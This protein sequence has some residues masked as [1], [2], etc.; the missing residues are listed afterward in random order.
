MLS[1][2]CILP[3]DLPE[4]SPGPAGLVEPPPTVHAESDEDFC[5][6]EI[7]SVSEERLLPRCYSTFWYKLMANVSIRQRP[8][9]KFCKV[10]V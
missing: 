10:L 9:M 2:T 6:E 4:A 7:S 1:R 8:E 5:T 3:L